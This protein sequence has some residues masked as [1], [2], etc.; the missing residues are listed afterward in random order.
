MYIGPTDTEGLHKLVFEVLDN[1]VDEA[2]AGICKHIDIVIHADGSLSIADDGR[3]IPTDTHPD[4]PDMSTV[5]VVLTILHAGG[6]FNKESYTFSGGLHGV[7]VSV[8]NALSEWLEVEVRRDGKIHRMR[9]ER[10]APVAP[11]TVTGD[12]RKRGTTIRFKADSLIF[13]TIDFSFDTIANRLRDLAFLNPGLTISIR[14]ERPEGKSHVFRYDGG[15]VELVR[16]LND[17]RVVIT[18]EPI[19]IKREREVTRVMPNGEERTG[20]AIV[21]LCLQYNDTYTESVYSYANN[22]NTFN[23]G[24]HLTGF[25]RAFTRTMNDYASRNDL[26]KKLKENLSQDDLKE[27]LTA[28]LSVKLSH[29]TFD[30]Q[31]KGRLVSTEVSGIVE[32]IVA[33]ALNEWLEENPKAARKMV[34]KCVLAATARIEARKAKDIIRKGA[35]EVSSLPGKLSDCSEKDPMKSELFIVEGDSAGGSARQGRDRHFQAILPLR[36]KILNVERARLDRVFGNEEIRSLITAL[37]C[38]VGESYDLS[39][40][41]YGK[42]IIMTDADVDGAHIRTLLLTFLFRQM[43]DLIERG[44]IYIAQPPLYKVKKGKSEKYL[45]K[46]E[47]KDRMLLDLGLEDSILYIRPMGKSKKLQ[48]QSDQEPEP[49]KKSEFRKLIEAIMDLES[50][51][52]QLI[53]K[54]F[55]LQEYLD[56]RQLEEAEGRLPLGAFI[57]GGT[58][59]FAYDEA[60][61]TALSEMEEPIEDASPTPIAESAQT[62]LL[63]SEDDLGNT[64][65]ETPAAM[66]LVFSV[67]DLRAEAATLANIIETI[68]G[69][70]LNADKFEV[71]AIEQYKLTDDRALFRYENE[72]RRIYLHNLRAILEAVKEAGKKGIMVSRYKGLG[73]M[74][75]TEL[76]ETTMDPA[77]RRLLQVTLDMAALAEADSMFS[78]LMGEDVDKRRHFIQR[79]APEVRNLDV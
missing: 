67:M 16:H 72:G 33:E 78:T 24:T 48:A 13:E 58:T 7:G 42:C 76:W 28:V 4:R 70:G 23:G 63:A 41:R 53:R 39:K 66:R 34:D 74:N 25:R 32:S 50:L 5:E 1:S 47:D 11:L 65:E 15:I 18:P 2:M 68:E 45:D 75:A 62:D 29:A 60:T 10:G 51:E 22:I 8:V 46:D 52:R 6:K 9:F 49:I 36:G 73:E 77:S 64:A 71:D 27:G 40:L 12:T 57:R 21:E 19:Y 3:G 38:G 26:L 30:S 37:G 43:R 35:L 59:K 54:G 20:K 31:V 69:L 17:G 55:R 44:H 61:Y 14:D 56:M 79:H